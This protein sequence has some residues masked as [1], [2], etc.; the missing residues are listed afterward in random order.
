MICSPF[1]I[2]TLAEIY[3]EYL[4]VIIIL[5]GQL[6]LDPGDQILQLKGYILLTHSLKG[7]MTLQNIQKIH[8]FLP[9]LHVIIFSCSKQLLKNQPTVVRPL[10]TDSLYKFY[11]LEI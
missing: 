10:F 5:I 4:V 8:K 6:Y 2:K 3:R 9:K 7:E 1:I 11:I